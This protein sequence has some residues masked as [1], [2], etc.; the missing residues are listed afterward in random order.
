MRKIILQLF[1]YILCKPDGGRGGQANA[2]IGLQ[3]GGGGV[4]EGP[5]LAYIIYEWPLTWHRCHFF[6]QKP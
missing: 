6:I 3:G 1:I 2:Y 4:Q 5:N